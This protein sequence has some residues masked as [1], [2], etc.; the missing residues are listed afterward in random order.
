M[1]APSFTFTELRDCA[2]RELKLRE[3][4]YPRR[5]EKKQMTQSLADVQIAMMEEIVALLQK[6]AAEESLFG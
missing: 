1:A 4:V 6:H 3:R 5:V 2:R